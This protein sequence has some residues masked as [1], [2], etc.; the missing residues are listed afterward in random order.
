M[1]VAR[2]KQPSL[3]PR[4][5]LGVLL[6]PTSLFGREDIGTL[7]PEAFAFVDW[8][9]QAGVTLWQILPLT[10]NGLHNSPYFSPSAFAGSP[11]LIDLEALGEHGLLE[12]YTPGPVHD[13]R[14]PFAEL[15]DT[16]LPL[17]LAAAENFLHRQDHPW[18]ATFRA[19]RASELWLDY[20]AHF[21]ALKEALAGAPWWASPR[22]PD[23]DQ[24][25]AAAADRGSRVR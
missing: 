17:L 19:F 18:Q 4:R 12:G 5:E 20:T 7:G 9:E 6:H 13:A 21:F 16:K 2:A 15:G 22:S 10:P 14:V 3:F 25:G 8:L 23:R 24:G 11:W 1:T